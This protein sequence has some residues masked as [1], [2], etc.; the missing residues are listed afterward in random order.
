[1]N[2]SRFLFTIVILILIYNVDKEVLELN[3][4]DE[5]RVIVYN[6]ELKYE[7]KECFTL[8]VN[9]KNRTVNLIQ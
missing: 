4:E 1:M 5:F 8:T 2:V 9:T 6:N 3:N 7:N